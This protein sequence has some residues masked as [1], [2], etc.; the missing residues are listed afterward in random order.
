MILTF[1]IELFLLNTASKQSFI[2]S[3]GRKLESVGCMVYHTK[4]DADTLIVSKAIEST[5]TSEMIVVGEDTDLLVLLL[6]HAD[7][8]S[9]E[10]FFKLEM[11]QT[12]RS[13]TVRRDILSI[14]KLW[15]SLFVTVYFYPCN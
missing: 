3:L 1:K 10:I 14:K 11:K 12:V 5:V 8:N 13:E 6:Y 2:N 9:H 4:S 15:T 7:L